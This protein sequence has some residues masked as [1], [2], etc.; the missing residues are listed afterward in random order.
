MGLLEELHERGRSYSYA[1][2]LLAWHNKRRDDRR[3]IPPVR[4]R[5]PRARR[6]SI[7]RTATSQE[8]KINI[9]SGNNAYIPEL[10]G[11]CSPKPH[12]FAV[13]MDGND[14]IFGLWYGF[15]EIEEFTEILINDA[16]VPGAVTVEEHKGTS[17]QT[18]STILS[19]LSGYTHTLVLDVNGTNRGVAYLVFRVPPGAVDGFPKVSVKI[20]GNCEIEDTRTPVTE[21]SDLPALCFRHWLKT[22]GVGPE[23]SVLDS[24]FETLVP[25]KPKWI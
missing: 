23:F 12:M 8:H 13:G 24:T 3:T 9:T 19:N 22:T 5:S 6:R 14:L 16:A 15:G 21:Y 1:A 20:K 4:I 18:A 2:E 11:P 17:A 10:Y 7:N 25:I